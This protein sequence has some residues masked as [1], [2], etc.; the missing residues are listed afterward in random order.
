VLTALAPSILFLVGQYKLQ[1]PWGKW[2][3]VVIL[4]TSFGAGMMLNTVRAAIEI[5]AKKPNEFKRTPKF[6][7]EKKDGDWAERKYQLKLDSIVYWELLL[8]VFDLI[9]IRLGILN[10]H[11][12]AAFYVALFAAGLLFT[13]LSTIAQ[14][15]HVERVR[16]R[17]S[18]ANG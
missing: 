13:S 18:A 6:G 7:M 5:V 12:F 17:R 1:R 10:G 8:V 11:W 16:L 3:P 4:I 15:I 14:N 9:T 2:L